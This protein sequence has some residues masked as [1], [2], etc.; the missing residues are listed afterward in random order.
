MSFENILII[1]GRFIK[2]DYEFAIANF[3]AICESGRRRL[4]QTRLGCLNKNYKEIA[5]CVNGDFN[6]I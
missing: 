6:I 3:Y 2:N 4:L 1:K 5:W